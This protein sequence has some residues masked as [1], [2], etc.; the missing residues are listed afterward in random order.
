MTVVNNEPFKIKTQKREA[1]NKSFLNKVDQHLKSKR[2]GFIST[3]TKKFEEQDRLEKEDQAN[4]ELTLRELHKNLAA[5]PMPHLIER[6]VEKAKKAAN[7]TRKEAFVGR[8]NTRIKESF[9]SIKKGNNA[10]IKDIAH[11][12][13]N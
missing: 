13:Q 4:E 12:E 1:S 10:A 11:Q 5:R 3:L 9:T 8:Q 7:K 6:H 2:D